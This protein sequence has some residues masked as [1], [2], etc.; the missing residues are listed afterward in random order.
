MPSLVDELVAVG[1][2]AADVVVP[3][4]ES[5]GNV[6]VQIRPLLHGVGGP[7]DAA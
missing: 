6:V 1:V 5:S 7:D 2:L 3:A 4:D